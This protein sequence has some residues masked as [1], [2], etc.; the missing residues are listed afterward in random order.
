MN[1]RLPPLASLDKEKS[2]THTVAF[3]L[4]EL[5]G[6]LGLIPNQKEQERVLMQCGVLPW[7]PPGRDR[8]GIWREE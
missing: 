2:D 5:L 8:S 3:R 7:Y 4:A 1:D 6:S